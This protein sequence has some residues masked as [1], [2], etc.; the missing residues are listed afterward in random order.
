[1]ISWRVVNSTSTPLVVE[2]LQRHA[3][4]LGY[5]P[6]TAAS[7]ASG[8]PTIGSGTLTCYSSCP[9]TMAT[10]LGSVAVPCTSYN[11]LEDYSM[12]ESRF[13]VKIPKNYRFQ[14]IY[15]S[16]AWFALVLSTGSDWSVAVQINTFQRSN[17]KYNQAPI[18]TMLPII[19]LRRNVTYNVKINVADND[20]DP[21][22]CFWS[23]G[24]LNEC[25]GVCKAVPASSVLNQTSCMLKF[26]GPS[27]GYYAIA[28]TIVDF[29]SL[30]NTTQ[31]SRVPL[32]FIFHVWDT[33]NTCLLPPVYLGDSP[34]DQCIYV[35][36]G[37]VVTMRIRIQIQCPG[38]NLSSVIA[39]YPPG[40]SQSAIYEDPYDTTINFFM[41]NYTAAANQVGQN[42]FC[43]AGVDSVG[44]QGDSTCLRF[45]VQLSTSSLNTLYIGNVTRYPIGTVSKFQSVWTILYPNATSFTR[46]LVEAYIRFKLQSTAEDFLTL[47]V[48]LETTNVLY[49]SDRLVIYTSIEFTPGQSFYISF[50]PGVFLEISTCLRNS[51]GITDSSFWP[52]NIVP[53]ITT[54]LSTT[55]TTEAPT[56]TLKV[57]T[58]GK[59]DRYILAIPLL[60][61]TLQ[62]PVPKTLPMTEIQTTIA[63]TT[64]T[65]GSST[66]TLTTEKPFT[67]ATNFPVSV[68]I[69]I[70][71]GGLIFLIILVWLMLY[72]LRSDMPSA[73]QKR[74][75]RDDTVTSK[76]SGRSITSIVQQYRLAIRTNRRKSKHNLRNNQ[77]LVEV[78]C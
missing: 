36:P 18:A 34:A 7:I 2:I 53:E 58:V 19:R 57:R 41:V 37:Q 69:I 61:S 4:R 66:I 44:N 23:N 29:E 32:Q 12:G 49:L 26:I 48:V 51:M 27:V 45:T 17:G 72:K 62:V 15:N 25:G 9:P 30:T 42:L 1:M 63:T 55:T 10:N 33:N 22:Q 76:R 3:W 74:S 5:Y 56:T 59:T 40:F 43:F 64:T 11:T 54:T 31:L 6:C 75:L 14:A 50:D 39:V 78:E 13:Q 60:L 38:A 47:N 28:L 77:H 16:S 24:S 71:I 21:Y 68:I 8:S 20:F 73:S 70:T 52:F 46:P 65:L 67:S 35:D